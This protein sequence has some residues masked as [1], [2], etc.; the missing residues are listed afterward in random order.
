MTL[1]TLCGT[2]CAAAARSRL[3]FDFSSRVGRCSQTNRHIRSSYS[4]SCHRSPTLC[5]RYCS[6]DSPSLKRAKVNLYP[7]LLRIK[8]TYE[9]VILD[10]ATAVFFKPGSKRRR[11]F[12]TWSTAK[13]ASLGALI[14]LKLVALTVL[15]WIGISY[16]ND[17]LESVTCSMPSDI[18]LKWVAVLY[19]R[20]WLQ[21]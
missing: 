19:Q 2:F 16:F 1:T 10:S 18:L 13:L 6:P 11:P 20:N 7:S 9:N 4:T 15:R 8:R 17:V 12:S 3:I 14:A 21:S 5:P